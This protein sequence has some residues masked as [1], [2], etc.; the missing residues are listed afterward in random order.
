MRVL[1]LWRYLRA[2]Y[3]LRRVY[4]PGPGGDCCLQA[5]FPAEEVVYLEIADPQQLSAFYPPAMRRAHVVRGDFTCAPFRDGSFEAAFVQRIGSR[6]GLLDE[7]YRLV[8]PG[9]LVVAHWKFFWP[10]PTSA[11]AQ[12][13]RLRIGH[14]FTP[15][16]A[17]AAFASGQAAEALRWAGDWWVLRRRHLAIDS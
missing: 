2:T 1:A 14:Y 3:G 12:E 5:A 16:P 15:L 8:Q 4:Y 6:L 11:A 17:P 7:L 9:G 13:R 10:R